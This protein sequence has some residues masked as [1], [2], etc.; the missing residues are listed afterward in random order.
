MGIEDP[1]ADVA[2]QRLP[3]EQ[4]DEDVPAD[5]GVGFAVPLEADPA[6]VAEQHAEIPLT[7]ADELG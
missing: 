3:A 5:D 2:E 1:D 4:V 7:D 6:D